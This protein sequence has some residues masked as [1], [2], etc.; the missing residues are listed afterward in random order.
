MVF[1]R[2]VRNET[3]LPLTRAKVELVPE[4][5][6]G[7]DV[8]DALDGEAEGDPPRHI[9][10]ADNNGQF[11]FSGIPPGRYALIAAREG[12][13]RQ[14]YG[15]AGANRYGVT[16]LVEAGKTVDNL[17]LRMTPAATV[18]GIVRAPDNA[19]LAAATAHAYRVQWTPSA[20]R[21]TLVQTALTND[22]GE[23]RLFW[24]DPGEYYIAASYTGRARPS[25]EFPLTPNLAGPDEG[26]PALYFPGEPSPEQAKTIRIGAN[27]VPG[28]DIALK[29]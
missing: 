21:L 28:V 3:D 19:P 12:F 11:N 14:G 17:V 13:L 22:R 2:V 1:G 15:Q 25:G 5:R 7:L 18:S 8:L 23:Y 20:R 16:V 9:V 29:P 4:A 6:L 27:A 26:Y 10:S 24:L